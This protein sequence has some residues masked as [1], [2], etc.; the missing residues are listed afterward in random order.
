MRKKSEKF[1]K[2]ERTT[3]EDIAEANRVLDLGI[4]QLEQLERTD[5]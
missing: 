4:A 3:A 1:H 5:E 2:Q